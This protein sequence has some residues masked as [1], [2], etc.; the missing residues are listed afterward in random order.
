MRYII[1]F[2]RTLNFNNE[3]LLIGGLHKADPVLERPG[4]IHSDDFV[5]CM[6]SLTINGRLL[7][8]TNPLHSFGIEANCARS[9][10]GACSK[11]DL[12]GS[13]ECQD[14]WKAHL[15]KCDGTVISTDCSVS[16]QAISVGE[17]GF[18]F[19]KISEKHRRMQ[20]LDT[21]YNGNTFW[22]K[23]HNKANV[24]VNVKVNNPAKTLTF[25]FRT[26]RKNGILFYAATEKYFT[27]IELL[28][29]KVT[30]ISKQNTVV[31]MTKADQKE[32]SDG[33]WHNITLIS[34]GRSI[35]LLV[36]NINVGE[37]LDPAGVHDFLDPYLTVISLGGVKS[38]WLTSTNQ[39]KF[40]GCLANFTINNEIQPFS[41]NGSIFKQVIRTGK[42]LNGCHSTFGVGSTQNP[43]PLRI[44]I[45]LVIVFFIILLVAISVSI[46]FYRLRKQKK[47]KSSGTGS[48]NN[49]AISKQNGG[50]AMLNAPNLIAG[51]NDSMINRN[52]HSN[53][54]SLNSYMS[55]NADITRNVGHIVG[56][57]LLSKKYKDREIMN[58][59]HPRPQRPDIIEREVV[60][61][62]PALREDHHPPPPPSTNTSHHHDLPS[63]IDLNSEVPEH[64]DLENASS[65]A[66]SDID[67]VYH[68]KGFREAAGARKYK[69]TPPPLAGYHHKHQNAQHRHSPHHPSGFPSRVLPQAAQPPSQPRQHQTTPLARLSPSSELSQQPRILTLHDISGKPLQ[70]ALLATTSSSGGVGKDALHSNSERSLNSPVMS[71]LSGQSS[72]AGRKTPSA[73][74]QVPQ[75][76]SVGSSAVGLTAEEIERINARQ[77]T[78]SLVSTLDAVSSSSEAPRGT[79]VGHHMSHR[80]HSPP[81]DNRSSTGS[82]DES[83]NDSFTCSEIEYDNTSINADKLEDARRQNISNA[84]NTKK[85]ILPPPYESFDSSFRGSLSTLVA[86]DDDLAP[87]VSS[88]LYR[89]ANGSPSSAALGWDH[90]FSWGN[91]ESMIGVFKDIAELPDSV[92]GR[93][94]SSL[95]LQNGTPKPS[96]EY[97]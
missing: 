64:Y 68:Y 32:V 82:D 91:F 27:L 7:N 50:P 49:T 71:Q 22:E 44:G 79:G 62:S 23:V 5:G 47:E 14:T 19:Y 46:I 61:K 66:P 94:S 51:T 1:S 41:G 45:T 20:L 57:E 36:D 33:A 77:R 83:G 40:E 34:I 87:H 38:D 73:P 24:K 21:F 48:K 28:D 72:S 16:L 12:C 15:C 90:L 93:M 85:P 67:I 69:A 80:H 89:Q 25:F 75:V 31:N 9:E 84:A 60:G 11:A 3:P 42:I 96:E 6:H 78:S 70:S 56:P 95:R 92:N 53:D 63:G 52:L 10:K 58:I 74:P 30:Y 17:N 55:D 26:H 13:G 81:D 8:L 39:N 59:D 54:T 18:L 4:Q 43:D 86:S 88:V 35:R 76:V 97:V 29:G 65:I 2:C 37:E